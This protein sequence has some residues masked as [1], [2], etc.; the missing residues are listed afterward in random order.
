LLLVVDN[1]SSYTGTLLDFLRSRS[2]QF[3]VSRYCDVDSLDRF[4]SVIL[5]GRRH[6]DAGANVANSRI[7]RHCVAEAKPLLG[8]CYGAEILALALGGTLRRTATHRTGLRDVRASAGNPLSGGTLRVRA[9]HRFEIAR[10][11]DGF[12]C[13]ASSPA[14]RYEMVRL[15]GSSIFGTQFH[16]E[17][18]PD[19]RRLIGKFL[20]LGGVHVLLNRT[21]SHQKMTG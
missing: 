10:L 14:C 16:P 9:S 20:D 8:I 1:G 6:G 11:P 4:G 18:T 3:A 17:D 21:G 7:V 12:E 19:G 13:I 15:H 2:A 5:S